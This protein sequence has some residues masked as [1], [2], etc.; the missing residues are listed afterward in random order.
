MKITTSAKKAEEIR[1]RWDR[2]A[3][4]VMNATR[5]HN[6]TSQQELADRLGWSR[7][8]I[9]NLESGRRAVRFGDLIMV[10]KALEIEPQTLVGR[11]MQWESQD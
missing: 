11:I 8:M 7:N 10:A 6:D 3:A 5:R 2:A 1:K 9:A 4:V